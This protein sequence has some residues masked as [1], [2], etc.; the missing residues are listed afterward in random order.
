M[1]GALLASNKTR[2][3]PSSPHWL[4]LLT[5]QLPV[6]WT[7]FPLGFCHPSSTLATPPLFWQS[8]DGAAE[9]TPGFGLPQGG[10][11]G[12]LKS[13][14]FQT[15][16]LLNISLTPR[17]AGSWEWIIHPLNPASV[18]LLHRATEILICFVWRDDS[19]RNILWSCCRNELS[20]G[21]EN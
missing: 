2:A 9:V 17:S 10:E 1:L 13:R 21:E 15:Q 5:Q 11:P 7:T 8:G 4:Q 19:N 20:E 3:F 6:H 12:G 16:V 18:L 14:D